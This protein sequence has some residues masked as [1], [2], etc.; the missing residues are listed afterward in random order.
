MILAGILLFATAFA[1]RMVGLSS[2]PWI[3]NGLETSLGLEVQQIAAG[4]F[5]NPFSTGWMT[6]PTL[7]LFLMALPLKLLG[8][9]ALS[10]RFLSPLIGALT[11]LATFWLGTKL[12]SVEVGLIA[13]VLLTGSHYH[14]HYS[15]LG[16]PIIWDGLLMLLAVGLLSLAW[17]GSKSGNGRRAAW[18]WAGLAV[19]LTAYAYTP[20]HVLPLILI[21]L[22]LAAILFQREVYAGTVSPYLWQIW[23]WR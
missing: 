8:A 21:L 6:A 4:L 19:G 12:W 16:L 9:S 17:Q 15:R 13:A 20:A 18:L 2:H 22:L 11:V 5:R 10:I 1:I 3:L 23:H 7:P 14:I